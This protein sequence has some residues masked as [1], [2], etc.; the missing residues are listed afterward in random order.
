MAAR[1]RF[2]WGFVAL[3][4]LALALVLWGTLG[5]KKAAQAKTPS[6]VPVTTAEVTV[7]D[8]PVTL[9]ELGTAQAW[10]GVLIRTQVNGRLLR[11]PVA[12]G[13]SVRAGQLL[14][15]IDDAPYRAALTQAQGALARDRAVLQEAR[16]N[17]ARYQMLAKQDSIARQQV[18]DQ[19]A[20]VKQDEGVVKLDEGAVAAAQVNVNY[21]RIVAP[22]AGKVGVRLVD[23]GNI[24]STSDTTGIITVNQVTPMAVTVSVPQNDFQT[25]MGLTDGFDRPLAVEALSQETGASLGMGEVRIADNQVDPKTG[26]VE[27]KARFANAPVRLWPG[28]FVNVKIRLKTLP[29]ALVVPTSA[30]N[31]GPDGAFA[32]VVGADR[33][34][35]VRPVAVA[36]TEG[37]L[38]VIRSGLK[39][40]EIVVTDGQMI[41]KPGSKVAIHAPA[42]KAAA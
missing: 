25:L 32:Y 9:T 28:Q 34:V 2:R 6:A 13:A 39:P 31:Q 41:L 36:V 21:C 20:Q 23:P 19:A 37:Q 29:Q 8:V 26:T 3:A 16:A 40:G 10:Q 15:E 18:E 12:E 30:V 1:R 22:V 14:A 4:V 42:K 17:L 24:V 27:L 33:K 38:S 35:S 7:Q 5:H 11:V